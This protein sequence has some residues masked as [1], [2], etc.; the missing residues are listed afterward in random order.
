[1]SIAYP[2]PPPGVLGAGAPTLPVSAPPTA[3]ASP[4]LVPLASR[5]PSP[6][7]EVAHSLSTA[8]LPPLTPPPDGA[9]DSPTSPACAQPSP[10][11]L[12]TSL[13]LREWDAALTRPDSDA[14]RHQLVHISPGRSGGVSPS[15]SADG[16]A[17]SR[18][19]LPAGASASS[20]SVPKL[21]AERDKDGHIEYKLKLIEPS[22][23][24]LE[25]LVSQMLWRLKQ[26]RNEAI[27]ELGLADD[28][29]VVGLTRAEMDASLRT[30]ERMA[31][32]LGATVIVVKEIVL[33][34]AAVDDDD[35]DALCDDDATQASPAPLT[36]LPC[37][38]V[39]RPDLDE[40]GRPRR[41]TH[42]LA[43][44]ET[45]PEPGKKSKHR[46]KGRCE[47][48]P[49]APL[50]FPRGD[51]R[52]VFGQSASGSGSDDDDSSPAPSTPTSTPDF[53]A[54]V[55]R[56]PRTR[57]V[58]AVSGDL[59]F[60]LDLIDCFRPAA[61][62]SCARSACPTPVHPVPL[63]VRSE[64]KAEARRLRS[65]ARRERRRLD[66]L[67]GDGT[68]P[69]STAAL[70]AG[71]PS[72][73]IVAESNAR[74]PVAPTRMVVGPHQPARPSSLRLAEPAPAGEQVLPGAADGAEDANGLAKAEADADD[75]DADGD[76][77]DADAQGPH[78]AQS[79]FLDS[80]LHVPLD[81]LS[82]SFADVCIVP[83]ARFDAGETTS[84]S[85]DDAGRSSSTEGRTD[86][87]SS[88]ASSCDASSCDAPSTASSEAP[89]AAS[90]E[91]ALAR[92]CSRT[93]HPREMICVEALVVR[94]VQHGVPDADLVAG[95]GVGDDVD[96]AW[97]FGGDD[98][99]WGLGGDD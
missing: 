8:S 95:G 35:D 41:G 74:A 54:A 97:A 73:S 23:E 65:S 20:A 45:V 50:A 16:S 81:S 94:K 90:G 48:A 91:R 64:R 77:A 56:S 67:R 84:E 43:G 12:S 39:R 44:T 88:I 4:L 9:P 10:A 93:V 75:A 63:A 53:V 22:A 46:K 47:R 1:M 85:G 89:S 17:S 27:Y 30:L 68:A 60:E 66:L 11:S 55:P 34:A 70:F 33:A 76:D 32:E 57:S 13:A 19:S 18:P 42:A 83:G 5:R 92:A 82:L 28:G 87:G 29:T 58:S 25:R 99:G 59:A 7:H 37:W 72:A 98:D 6:W 36:A 51:R 62:G 79:S 49:L 96:D 71:P 69:L 61:L 24:R 40:H 26:G 80:L 52:I 2:L 3:S 86:L 78:G 15:S 38:P 31:S 21:A 14:R